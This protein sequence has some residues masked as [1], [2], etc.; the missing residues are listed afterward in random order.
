MKLS[1]AIE[2]YNYADLLSM[3]PDTLEAFQILIEHAKQSEPEPL[4]INADD[5]KQ[6]VEELLSDIKQEQDPK[7]IT[8][9]IVEGKHYVCYQGVELEE[10]IAALE[11]AKISLILKSMGK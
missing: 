3:E 9:D 6:H 8:I 7:R 1:E 5:I 10:V 2:Q 11:G 4:S